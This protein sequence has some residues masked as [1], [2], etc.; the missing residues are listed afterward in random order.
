MAIIA[1]DIILEK[2]TIASGTAT[3]GTIDLKRSLLLGIQYPSAMTSATLQIQQSADGVTFVPIL[4]AT[5]TAV[6]N[7]VDVTA[8]SYIQLDESI[9]KGLNQIRL[10]T[11]GNE[12]ADREIILYTKQQS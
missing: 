12:A 1:A 9:T 10:V 8:S 2:T 5:G 6:Y 7:L 11:V 4:D 3:S